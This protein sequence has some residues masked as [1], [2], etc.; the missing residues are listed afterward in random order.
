MD[1]KMNKIVNYISLLGMTI[2]T[3]FSILDK[4]TTVFYIMFLFWCDELIKT[5]FD[6]F[7]YYFRKKNIEDAVKYISNV[8]SR[9]FLLAVYLIFIVVIFGLLIDWKNK[10]LIIENLMVLFFKNRLFNFTIII[11]IIRELYFFYKNKKELESKTLFSNGIL[12]LH[13]SIILGVLF[14]FISTRKIEFF[15]EYATII[16]IVPFLILKIIFELKAENKQVQSSL[17]KSTDN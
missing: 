12:I 6:V 11:F 15:K 9:F 2:F 13:I 17:D 14:W 5:L 3:V 16:S 10:D 8:K 1:L 7:N 4:T